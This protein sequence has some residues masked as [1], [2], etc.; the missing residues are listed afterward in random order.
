MA[1][2]I[3]V[4][5]LADTK[6]LAANLNKA[7]GNLKGFGDTA[8]R[9]ADKARKSLEH[10]GDSAGDVASGSAQVAGAFG[11]IG[12]S[13]ATMGF[14]SDGTAQTLDTMGMAIMGVTGVADLA[15]VVMAKLKLQT[16][17]ATIA[18]KA[19]AVGDYAAATAAK[20]FA[21]AQRVLNAVM[22]GNPIA[23][24]VIAVMALVAAFILAYK[25]SATFRKIVQGAMNGAKNAAKAFVNFFRKTVPA[26]FSAVIKFIGSK[27]KAVTGFL[28]KPINAA[29]TAIKIG[30]SKVKEGV[31]K[32]I[33]N[34]KDIPGK[35]RNVISN[36][37]NA[38]KDFIGGFFRGVLSAAGN[39]GGFI[40]SLM[41]SIKSAI[42]S[43]LRL[44][45][46]IDFDKGPLHIHTTLIPALAKGGIVTSP[47][48]ALI[49]EAGPEAV[50]PLGKM[51]G[52]G[53]GKTVNLHFYGP[54]MGTKEAVGKFVRDALNEYDAT[55]GVSWA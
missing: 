45:L 7:E 25:K 8:D 39:A 11:D 12:G 21:V 31:S 20:A 18:A 9:E 15:E 52:M 35:I 48:L 36:M 43:A 51:D 3:A 50:V 30:F 41:S 23:L 5:I 42:N 54:I 28:A 38:G 32:L 1:K 49:G 4:S 40:S 33:G 26:A 22:A 6:E 14:I 24:V 17:G 29:V 19:K 13:L 16:I 37:V 47:T 53:S 10:V 27:W 46:T 55:G 2:T 44:P 34:I